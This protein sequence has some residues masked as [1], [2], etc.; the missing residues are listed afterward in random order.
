MMIRPIAALVT[1]AVGF[2]VA[3]ALSE[4]GVR[5]AGYHPWIS[6][7][8]QPV[9]PTL[10]DPDPELG[11]VSRPGHWRY[12]PYAPGGPP[13]EV[14]ISAERTRRTRLDDSAAPEAR[15]PELLLLGC[16]FTFGVGVSDDETYAWQ[17]QA[18]RPDLDVRNRGTGAYGTLQALWLLDRVL[19]SGERPARVVYGF[20]PEHG[21]RNV[22]DP[23][24]MKALAMLTG[25]NIV[26]IPYCEIDRDGALRCHPPERYPHWPLREWSAAI[27]LLQDRWYQFGARGREAAAD[28]VTR[29]L[30]LELAKRSRA[31]G[32]R[33]SVLLL[34]VDAHGR[35]AIVPFA[36]SQGID[37]IDCDRTIRAPDR[38][39][40]DL[41]PNGRVHQAWAECLA[42]SL[43]P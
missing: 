16:S 38:V 2:V 11:W 36:R 17:L 1:L 40:G 10:N 5:A 14:T 41:H 12:G 43:T 32:A 6:L 21:G 20:I 3:A 9:E 22:G 24:W 13:V 29:R 42:G 23:G 39:P 26:T 25:Q 35:E 15:R 37:V 19:A 7:R 34:S 33:F 28:E 27:T 4:L 8:L 30:V 18:L 31:A